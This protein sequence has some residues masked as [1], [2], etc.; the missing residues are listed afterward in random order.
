MRKLIVLLLCVVLL[1]A[2]YYRKTNPGR[3]GQMYFTT[4]FFDSNGQEI[5]RKSYKFLDQAVKIYKKNPAVQ[6]EVRGYTDASGNEASNLKLSRERAEKVSQALQAR[7]IPAANLLVTGY[8]PEKPIASNQTPEGRQR[9]RRVEI[10][11][12]YPED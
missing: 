10:E 12:P 9:N 11:F 7:G 5:A 6:V 1:G 2:C 8:G 4:I 3:V